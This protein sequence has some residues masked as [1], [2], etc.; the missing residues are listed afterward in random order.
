MN[1][2]KLI[3]LFRT[4]SKEEFKE[5]GLFV[6]SPFFNREKVQVKFF[7]MIFTAYP[8]FDSVKIRKQNIYSK[9]FPG[10]RYNDALMRNT[11][12]DML[13][14]AK[15]FL[16]CIHFRS[17]NFHRQYVLLKELTNRRQQELFKAN[18]KSAEK[19]L[20]GSEIR[21]EIFYQ[22]KFLLEDEKRR[23][24]VVNSS[25]ILYQDDN[26]NEQAENIKIAHLTEDIKL[27]AILIN[28]K[29]FV[30]DHNFDL[31]YFETIRKYIEENFISFRNIPYITIFY[32]CI[33]LFL[34]EEKKYFDELKKE[35]KKHF[36]KLTA[37]DRKNMFMVLTNHGK[38]RI[39]KGE[40]EFYRELF[41]INK[42]FIKT[43]AC[44]EGNDF[45]AHY[46]Y[47]SVALNAIAVN[48]YGW[49]EK[50]IHEYKNEMHVNFRE[51]VYNFCLSN[52]YIEKG[53]Y[54]KALEALSKVKTFDIQYKLQV[55]QTLLLIYFCMNETESFLSLVDSFRHF[56][57]RN[58]YLR[59]SDRLLYG[60]FIKYINKLYNVKIKNTYMPGQE[61]EKIKAEL[62]GM[63]EIVRKKWLTD[64]ADE[65]VTSLK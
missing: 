30:H 4:F 21:D 19:E 20:M 23:N 3:K 51:S 48:E 55:N 33:M 41:E 7:K 53:N 64:R 63:E 12:S 65:L 1:K 60:N 59:K 6:E 2:S 44:Y 47:A 62:E 13:N 16:R 26:I 58:K 5:F 43:K 42:D 28:Q 15:E 31:T 14:L 52:L 34:T 38:H 18:F 25:K 45:I 39:K 46:I 11:V 49:A 37:T 35:V 22:N 29:K 50:F 10:K 56:L 32:N 40:F 17:E 24:V 61:L 36:E 9:L 8:D 27:Y 57:N 54:E